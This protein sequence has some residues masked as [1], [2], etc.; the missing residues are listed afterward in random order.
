MTLAQTRALFYS[1]A[2]FNWGAVLI[3]MLFARPLGLEPPLQS[4]FGQ[5]TL[6]AI[7]VFGCGYGLVGM[8]PRAYRGIVAL[9]VLGKLAVVAIVWANWVSGS[10]TPQMALLVSGD[11]IYSL[12]FLRFL[13]R[14]PA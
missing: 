11:V 8:A 14:T 5:I 12:L 3:F 10:T 1:A 13:Q 9:G 6:G 4:L 7:F 2:L